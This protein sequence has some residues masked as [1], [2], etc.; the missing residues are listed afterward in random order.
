MGLQID[1]VDVE[2]KREFGGRGEAARKIEYRVSV[3]ADA[4]EEEVMSL[5]RHT[6]SVAE[7]QNTLRQRLPVCSRK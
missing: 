5:V 2:V 3:A 7:I 4:T 6:D 1:S